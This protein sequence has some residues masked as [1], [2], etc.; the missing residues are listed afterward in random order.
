QP[1]DV[2]GRH[3]AAERAL[4]QARDDLR[5]AGPLGGGRGR[6]AGEDPAAARRIA[7]PFDRERPA[8]LEGVRRLDALLAALERDGARALVAFGVA[9]V[10]EGDGELVLARGRAKADL[11]QPAVD[12]LDGRIEALIDRLVIGFAADVGPV[13]LFAVE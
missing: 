9:A 13:D 4:G 7:E 8:D 3:G 12:L 1:V 5:G 11:A 2:G 6:P 10:D